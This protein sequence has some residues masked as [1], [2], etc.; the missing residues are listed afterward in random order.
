M[1]N[2]LIVSDGF[3]YGG[4]ETRT[5]RE[6]I[7]AKKHHYNVF[8]ACIDYNHKYNVF[9]QVL[10]L[11]HPL[12]DYSDSI[13]TKNILATRDQIINF[14][15]ENHIDII[16]CH[17]YWCLLPTALAAEKLHIP[18]TCTLHGVASG[19]FINPSLTNIGLRTI[20]Y[21]TLKYGFDQII[22]VAEY[23]F[24]QYS[25]L[26]SNII[27]TRNGIDVSEKPRPP[28]SPHDGYFCIAS[29]LD[30]PKTKLIKEFLP[31][32][33]ALPETQH[34]DIFGDG[35]QLDPLKTF[36]N[37]NHFNKIS[38]KGW[39]RN[40][41][42][43]FANNHYAAIFGMGQVVL[44]ALNSNTPAGVL[45]YGGFA[46]LINGDKNLSYFAENNFTDWKTHKTDLKKELQKL[47][48]NP[49]DYLLSYQEISKFNQSN[50]WDIHFKTEES[51]TYSEKPIFNTLNYLLDNHH[52]AKLDLKNF[53]SKTDLPNMQNDV[54]YQLF[55]ENIKNGSK[56]IKVN[57]LKQSNISKTIEIDTLKKE[58]NN[59]TSS[60]FWKAT[61]PLREILNKLH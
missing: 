37:Q 13:K 51:F 10:I 42:Q 1:K 9:K 39:G 59:I 25:Y 47:K 53:L 5:L 15:K 58:L 33:H 36:V 57:E 52:N 20:Y 19:N 2:I 56:A 14:C 22:A 55:L 26:S 50:I 34:V 27:I 38:V 43:V 4:F 49:D 48:K 24:K 41:P 44:E 31:T 3:L 8:L 35:D 32:L 29:R 12:S 21:L 61:K 60:G 11:K 16:E 46:G 18:I 6:L 17:P 28:Y 30:V 45:G 54:V 23:L 7:E 40:L